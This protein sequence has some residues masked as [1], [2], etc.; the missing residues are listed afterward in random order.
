MDQFNKERD[1]PSPGFFFALGKCDSLMAEALG[2]C[3]SLLALQR[4][5]IREQIGDLLVLER[6]E[7]AFGH[8]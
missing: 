1:L 3:L 8:Q 7:Q 6:I 2:K 4:H 5:Q